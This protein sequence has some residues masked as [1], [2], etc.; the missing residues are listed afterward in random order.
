MDAA[1][2]SEVDSLRGVSEN[3]MLGQMAPVGTGVFSV[4]L[5]Q[6]MLDQ[7]AVSDQL[8]GFDAMAS[9]LNDEPD[10]SRTPTMDIDYSVGTDNGQS[11]V[12]LYG[13]FSPYM[14]DF[15]PLHEGVTGAGASSTAHAYRTGGRSNMFSP[16]SPY[17][18]KTPSYSRN[19]WSPSGGISPSSPSYDSSLSPTSPSYSPQDVSYS[20]NAG[21]RPTS[22]S[23]SPTSPIY[24]PTSPSYS[25]TSPKYSP[26][27]PK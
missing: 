19:Q 8:Y 1:T 6:A 2:F 15:S 4:Y 17:T 7:Y 20:P 11:P 27:S 14:G 5:D 18:M 21:L 13:S 12:Q 26:T 23:Y 25:P 24:S 10:G 16:K 22:P 9:A 3:I